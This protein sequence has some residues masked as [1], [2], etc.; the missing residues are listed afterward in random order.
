MC[1]KTFANFGL[2]HKKG[3]DNLVAN[4]FGTLVAAIGTRY[5]FL[6]L[7]KVLEL[8]STQMGNTVKSR[9]AIAALGCRGSLFDV[10]GSEY[11]SRSLYGLN[12]VRLGPVA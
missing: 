12:L 2:F 4:A 10:L 1:Y 8:G 9:F 6:T 7:V 5:R 11:A 3:T